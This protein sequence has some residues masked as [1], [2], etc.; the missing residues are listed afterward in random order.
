MT[1]AW[2]SANLARSALRMS[3]WKRSRDWK[4]KIG[5]T[6]NKIAS[7]DR[8]LLGAVSWLEAL[9]CLRRHSKVQSL[10]FDT[11][12]YRMTGAEKKKSTLIYLLAKAKYP[13][14]TM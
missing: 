11:N 6:L 8:S 9:F 10:D 3:G 5:F 7:A 14:D 12:I 13:T 4:K 1:L 2:L